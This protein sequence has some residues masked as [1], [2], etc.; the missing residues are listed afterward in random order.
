MLDFLKIPKEFYLGDEF[1]NKYKQ[2]IV[3]DENTTI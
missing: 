1:I 3:K 2:F